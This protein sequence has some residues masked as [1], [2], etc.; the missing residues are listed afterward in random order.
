MAH[1]LTINNGIAEMA[2][3]GQKPWHKLGQELQPGAD[4]ETWKIA[5][6]M[7]WR[8]QRSK[9]R[10]ATQKD[11]GWQTIDDKHVLFRSDNKQLLG[12]VSDRFKVVQPTEV[13]EFF[14]DLVGEAGYTLETAGTLFGGKR[15][16]ALANTGA[17]ADVIPGD[18]LKGYLLLSTGADGQTKT[19]VKSVAERVV[20]HN[21]IQMAL[22]EGGSEYSITHGTNFDHMAAKQHLGLLGRS[23]DQCLADC[24]QLAG[25]SITKVDAEEF[26]GSLLL[27]TRAVVR[28]D[29]DYTQAKSY[30]KIM[31]LFNSEAIGIELVG[32][33]NKWNLLNAITQY[34]DHDAKA[35]NDAN[36]I[37][38]AWF[39]RGNVIK[40]T[41][42]RQLIA[43]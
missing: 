31:S 26:V 43:A 5:A 40:N 36:R 17:V 8:I 30:Q 35:A 33:G 32:T 22:R 4:I 15:F 13:L 29:N 18:T 41:A 19:V 16:W 7:N 39:G 14:R 10:F 9:V 23:F 11:G 37:D 25:Q 34:V 1:E 27:Q 2:Y 38:S 24:R 28:D 21:T 42:F 12:V 6:G 3:V 20:C